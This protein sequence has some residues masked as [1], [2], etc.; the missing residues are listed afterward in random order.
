MYVSIEISL[1][2]PLPT[3]GAQ[4]GKGGVKWF[5]FSFLSERRGDL[6]GS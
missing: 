2:L 4:G 6:R 1:H 5:H 3:P